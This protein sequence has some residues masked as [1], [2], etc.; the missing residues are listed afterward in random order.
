MSEQDKL[1]KIDP[2]FG[3]ERPY[4]SHA[5]QFRAYHGQLAWLWNP[6]TAMRRHPADIASD[7]FGILINRSEQVQP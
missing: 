4:P 6:W 3:T 7:P 1:M 5:G 2:A